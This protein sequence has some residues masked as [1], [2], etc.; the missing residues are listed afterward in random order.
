[1]TKFVLPPEYSVTFT[2]DPEQ[3]KALAAQVEIIMLRPPSTTDVHALP[4]SRGKGNWYNPCVIAKASMV[5]AANNGNPVPTV[6]F[7]DR[8]LWLNQ[9]IN[10]AGIHVN[11]TIATNCSEVWQRLDETVSRVCAANKLDDAHVE[12]RI[13]ARLLCWAVRYVY[14]DRL[15]RFMDWALAAREAWVV[16][17]NPVDDQEAKSRANIGAKVEN[18]NMLGACC[19]AVLVDPKSITYAVN[20]HIANRALVSGPDRTFDDGV[21][22]FELL[23]DQWEK[24]CAEE[25]VLADR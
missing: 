21:E 24:A 5:H 11:D 14:G 20:E 10:T 3:I 19:G 15:P 25:G 18:D 22:F 1:M 8:P 17:D 4:L 9:V 7:T 2:I 12:R 13:N 6:A 23:L 16:S